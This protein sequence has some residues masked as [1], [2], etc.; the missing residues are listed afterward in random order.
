MRTAIWSAVSS[1]AQAETDKTSLQDQVKIGMDDIA[2]N[3]WTFTQSYIVPGESRTSLISLSDA[4]KKIPQLHQLLEDATKGNFEILYVYDLNRFRGLMLQIFEALATYRIQIYNHDDPQTIFPQEAYTPERINAARLNLKLHDILSGQEINTLQKHYREKMPNRIEIKKLHAGLGLP[5]YG[6]RKPNHLA[7]DKDAVLEIIPAEKNIILK[8]K[9][10]FLTEG[11]SVTEIAKRLNAAAIPSPRGK[12]WWASIVHY[13]LANPFYA[14]IVHFGTTKRTIDKRKGKVTRARSTP[15]TAVGIHKPIW[16]IHTHKRILQEIERRAKA[17]PGSSTR[18]LTRL[19]HCQCGK[20]MWAQITPEGK[21]WR[22]SSL[23][24]GHTY[25]N[26]TKA[27]ELF[28]PQLIESLKTAKDLPL[29]PPIDKTPQYLTELKTLQAKKKKWMDLYEDTAIDK[30]DLKARL[31]DINHRIEITR[32]LLADLQTA[33]T[34]KTTARQN[35]Q[36]IA[37]VVEK[38]PTF[39]RTAPPQRV[40]ANLH[41]FIQAIHLTKDHTLTIEFK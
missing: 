34:R 38:Y 21:Y 3:K 7:H 17:Q 32:Q 37:A 15:V 24:K 28:I 29:N 8:I 14:G 19:L 2:R 11:L 5:P 36:T 10:Y 35:L 26:D 31:A 39:I 25:I 40:N 33:T 4:E 6:Y 18:I 16:D 20:L 22:C 23:Q 30:D 9:N 1:K 27:L 12:K 13:I 41:T